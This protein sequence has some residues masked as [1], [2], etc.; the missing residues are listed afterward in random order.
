MLDPLADKALML[1]ALV[2]LGFLDMGLAM[3]P[4]PIWFLVLV[5]GRDV[6][7]VLGYMVLDRVVRNVRVRPHWTGKAATVFLMGTITLVLLKVSGFWL[8]TVVAVASLLTLASLL[9][10]LWR[11]CHDI[12]ASGY[13]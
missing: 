10:Y 4:L 2:I 6:F 8:H 7:L 5:L 3:P 11:G 1:S 9:V 12:Q 13:H